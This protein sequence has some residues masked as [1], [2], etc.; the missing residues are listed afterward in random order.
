MLCAKQYGV[1]QLGHIRV[2]GVLGCWYGTTSGAVCQPA[3]LA[4]LPC[5]KHPMLTSEGAGWPSKEGMQSGKSGFQD[6]RVKEELSVW[7]PIP[8]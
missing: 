8:G 4:G 2:Q 5:Q 6:L 1:G 7:I 3:C